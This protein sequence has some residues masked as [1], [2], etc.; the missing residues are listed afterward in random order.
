MYAPMELHA[1]HAAC[2]HGSMTFCLTG[3]TL[4]T[5]SQVGADD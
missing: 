2:R 1:L 4:L 3:G 5:Y